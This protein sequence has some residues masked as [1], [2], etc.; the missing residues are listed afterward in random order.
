VP[1]RASD[2]VFAALGDPTRRRLVESLAASPAT[3]TALARDLPISRQAVTKHLS[4][5]ASADL[6]EAERRGRET[7][8]SLRPEPLREVSAWAD[9]VGAEWTCGVW[10]GACARGPDVT[11]RPAIQAGR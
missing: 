2:S 9:R 4:L 6:V 7:R 1:E 3:A 8:Y 11:S 5:L 10:S